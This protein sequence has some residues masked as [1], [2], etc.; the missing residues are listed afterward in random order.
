MLATYNLDV[1]NFYIYSYILLVVQNCSYIIIMNLVTFL[2]S[3]IT[4]FINK[5]YFF[6]LVQGNYYNV[7]II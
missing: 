7:S 2:F 1:K 4:L 3:F 5:L 6:M